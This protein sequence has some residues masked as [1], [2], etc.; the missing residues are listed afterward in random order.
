MFLVS[1]ERV[2]RI[3][4]VTNSVYHI[5]VMYHMDLISMH[6][7][8]SMPKLLAFVNREVKEMWLS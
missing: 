5:S 4:Q 7:V 2:G 3:G 8:C 6:V 1:W